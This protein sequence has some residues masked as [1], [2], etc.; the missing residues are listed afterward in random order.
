MK[1]V[2]PLLEVALVL[3]LLALVLI[4]PHGSYPSSTVTRTVAPVMGGAAGNGTTVAI[5]PM[6]G[7]ITTTTTALR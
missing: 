5:A 6:T 7:V 2:K 4:L 3:A 1:A